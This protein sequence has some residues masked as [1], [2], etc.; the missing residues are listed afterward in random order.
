MSRRSDNET[1]AG[2]K[3]RASPSASEHGHQPAHLKA[4]T[5]DEAPPIECASVFGPM[6]LQERSKAIGVTNRLRRVI[7]HG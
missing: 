6:I 1:Q 2:Q 3:R 4:V 7:T 5:D